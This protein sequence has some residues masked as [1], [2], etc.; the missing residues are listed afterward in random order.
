LVHRVGA[1]LERKLEQWLD[2]ENIDEHG[3]GDA[4]VAATW[5][6][7]KKVEHLAAVSGVG[8]AMALLSRLS[9]KHQEDTDK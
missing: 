1:E 5:Y 6:L 2:G 9:E 8:S 7:A 4:L 3:D